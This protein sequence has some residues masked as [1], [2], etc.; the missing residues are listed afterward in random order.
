MSTK[1]ILISGASTGIGKAAAL[2]LDQKGFKVYA[3]VRRAEDGKRLEKQ[4]RQ[5]KSLLLDVTQEE[6]VQKALDTIS[7]ENDGHLFGLINNAGIVVLGPM[8]CLDSQ[9]LQLQIDVNVLGVAR[10]IRSSLPL[11]RKSHGRIINISSTSGL[12]ALPF[13]GAYAASKFALEGLSDSLRVEL[14]PFGVEVILIEPGAVATPLW[15]KTQEQIKGLKHKTKP[16]VFD[17]YD[18]YI[19]KSSRIIDKVKE[20]AISVD[21]VVEA[22]SKALNSKRPKQRYLVGASARLQWGVKT[23]LPDSILDY[24]RGKLIGKNKQA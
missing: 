2:Y 10:L 1:S 22:I 11:L 8:E 13:A 12:L 9:D 7:K 20:K 24:M 5:L 19:N 23:F 6:D 4:S 17:L 18:S 21:K 3:G 14:R 16:E 15:Q